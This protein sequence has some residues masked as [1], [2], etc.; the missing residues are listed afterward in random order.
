MTGGRYG[1]TLDKLSSKGYDVL[2]I[3]QGLFI[4]P[5]ATSY[6]MSRLLRLGSRDPDYADLLSESRLG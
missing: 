3:E 2:G 4:N 5:E 1:V 6:G